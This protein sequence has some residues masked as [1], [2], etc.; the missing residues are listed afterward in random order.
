MNQAKIKKIKKACFL[1]RDG[2]INEDIGYLYKIEDFRWISG[3]I[4]AIK[5]LKEKSFLVIV[6]TNQSGIKRGYYCESDV[7]KLHQWMNNVLKKKETQIDDFFFSSELP[8]EGKETRRKPSPK[9]INEA[10]EKYDLNKSEC[11]L[12]GDKLSD[13]Q[14]AKNSKIKGFLFEGGDLLDRI[15]KILKELKTS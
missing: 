13:I 9:M 14:A 10:V 4:E 3:A 12:V 2:V 11:F 6:I 15:K 1:D 5:F 7:N 8:S